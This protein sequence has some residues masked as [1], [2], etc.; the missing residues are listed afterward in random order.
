MKR[1]HNEYAVKGVVNRKE[2][3]VTPP[4]ENLQM[5]RRMQARRHGR[6]DSPAFESVLVTRTVTRWTR[7]EQKP[8]AGMKPEYAVKWDEHGRP[9]THALC[10]TLAEAREIMTRIKTSGRPRDM[11]RVERRQV[12]PWKTLP[13][14]N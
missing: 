2:E 8:V 14:A 9:V 7:G 13:D 5:M 10:A 12:S 1:I 4:S 11:L 3:I 6:S